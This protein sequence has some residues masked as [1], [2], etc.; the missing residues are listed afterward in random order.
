MCKFWDL[1]AL[2]VFCGQLHTVPCGGNIT[3]Q[4]GTIYSSGFPNQY[5]NSQDCT[6]AFVVSPGYGIYLNFTLLQTE[7]YNDFI[8]V[9]WVGFGPG[10]SLS[11][12]AVLLEPCRSYVL[13]SLWDNERAS[14]HEKSGDIS[15][16]LT[17]R[18]TAQ[19]GIRKFGGRRPRTIRYILQ[20][21]IIKLG[22][23]NPLN[24]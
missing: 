4:N 6:W 5:P 10:G 19:A 15:F 8:T 7:P 24:P 22:K 12:S 14:H 13:L 1:V 21:D 3:A 20:K 2:N 11:F 18:E 16:S 17:S 23:K 9:W